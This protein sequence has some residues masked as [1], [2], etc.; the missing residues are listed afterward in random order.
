MKLQMVVSLTVHLGLLLLYLLATVIMTLNKAFIKANDAGVQVQLTG[1][2]IE[3]NI[4][5]GVHVLLLA[6]AMFIPSLIGLFYTCIKKET[7]RRFYKKK[8]RVVHVTFLLV[9]ILTLCVLLAS[10]AAGIGDINGV[11]CYL[12]NN[13]C[14]CADLPTSNNVCACENL[15]I[16]YLV[17]IVLS[18]C[19][20]ILSLLLAAK[21]IKCPPRAASASVG[22]GPTENSTVPTVA[23]SSAQNE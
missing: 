12:D 13:N 21:L 6:V 11:G 18:L 19:C 16:S 15:R 14:V 10:E 7:Q 20:E 5:V 2:Q 4:S 22:Q 8:L 23:I 17:F 3:P 1:Y 9:G